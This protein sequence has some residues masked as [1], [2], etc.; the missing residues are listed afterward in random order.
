MKHWTLAIAILFFSLFSA[1]LQG[2][3]AEDESPRLPS[4]LYIGAQATTNGLG[5]NLGYIA[6]KRLTLKTG[7]EALKFDFDFPYEENDISYDATFQYKTGGLFLLADYFYARSLYLS[8]GVVMNNFQP[9]F[10]GVAASDMTYGDITI[11]ASKVG[12]FRFEVE[13]DLKFSPYVAAGFRSFIGKAKMVTWNIETGLYYMG[14]PKL[15][16]ET[17][18]LLAPTSDPAHGH[19]Q[20]LE[21]QFSV[22]KYYPIV[23]FALGVRLF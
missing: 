13:P 5:F 20:N 10:E 15:N 18:G 4:G 6:G 16:I 22:Y 19:Q 9:R 12:D 14:P 21:N 1:N 23:K 11:P 17:T 3:E 2:Q 8:G 7:V